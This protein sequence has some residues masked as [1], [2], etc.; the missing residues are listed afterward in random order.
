[1][2]FSRQEYW[3]GLPFPPPGDLPDPGF[4]VMSPAWQVHSLPL[5][6][7][8]SP[9]KWICNSLYEVIFK[10]FWAF[11]PVLYMRRRDLK[12]LS[13]MLRSGRMIDVHTNG[14]D[15]CCRG[16]EVGKWA[17]T[18]RAGLF[19]STHILRKANLP[20]F[21]ISAGTPRCTFSALGKSVVLI[22]LVGANLP[23]WS[24]GP[25]I[26]TSFIRLLCPWNFPGKNTG[27]SCYFLLQGIFLTQGSNLGLLYCR[28]KPP[29]K[30]LPSWLYCRSKPPGKPLPSWF[31]SFVPSFFISNISDSPPY[32]AYKHTP[33]SPPASLKKKKTGK[34]TLKILF[35]LQWQYQF[36]AENLKKYIYVGKGEGK[37][38]L[39]WI[40][41]WELTTISI[42][43]HI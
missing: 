16:S 20:P 8:G 17:L 41:H 39:L 21:Q 12:K 40:H 10:H 30:P 23:S 43:V 1:M 32:A 26:P 3:T 22:L 11:D 28:S 35:L 29:G 38:N 27:V 14:T 5:S 4:K 33:I 25:E 7:Q 15:R 37:K 24:L 34:K 31:Q 36:I 9:G 2:E 18:G 13:M 42:L 19:P 6:H